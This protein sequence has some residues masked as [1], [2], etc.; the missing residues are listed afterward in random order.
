MLA[1]MFIHYRI[2]FRNSDANKNERH[3]DT[4]LVPIC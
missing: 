1:Q 4:Q 3:T 2:T